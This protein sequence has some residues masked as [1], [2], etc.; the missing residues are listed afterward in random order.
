[1][2]VGAHDAVMCEAPGQMPRTDWHFPQTEG[3]TLPEPSDSFSRLRGSGFNQRTEEPDHLALLASK[4]IKGGFFICLLIS[5]K[6][7][8]LTKILASVWPQR[9]SR[10]A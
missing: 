10:A 6:S 5:E 8:L 3:M 7:Q 9:V 4:D 1:M 2:H